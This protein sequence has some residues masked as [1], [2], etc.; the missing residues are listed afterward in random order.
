MHGESVREKRE[1]EKRTKHRR[2]MRDEAAGRERLIMRRT[3]LWDECEIVR[4]VPTPLLRRQVI[5]KLPLCRA[6]RMGC[7]AF[8]EGR[9]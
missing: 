5:A 2:K 1:V 8:I 7:I 3:G 4:R 9:T 6:L